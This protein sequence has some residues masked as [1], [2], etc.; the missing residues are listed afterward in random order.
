MV[1]AAPRLATILCLYMINRYLV[2]DADV[3]ALPGKGTFGW[4]ARRGKACQRQHQLQYL[5]QVRFMSELVQ[6]DQDLRLLCQ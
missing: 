5:L 6:C 1:K 4:G 2:A 3:D